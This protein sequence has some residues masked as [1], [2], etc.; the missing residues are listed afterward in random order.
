MRLAR[1]FAGWV[2]GSDRFELAAPVPFSVVCFRLKG[3]KTDEAHERVLN[4]V[5]RSGEVLLSHTK[6]EGVF[7][8]R[9]AIGHLRTTEQHVRRA[10][11]LLNVAVSSAV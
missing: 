11:E 8:F 2:E 1:V 3:E 5:N 4:A 6:L 9:L 7:A 10:W